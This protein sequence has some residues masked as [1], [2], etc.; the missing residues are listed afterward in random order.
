VQ[1]GRAPYA[2]LDY[3]ASAPCLQQVA[4]RVAEVLPWYSSVH[5]GTGYLSQ[6]STSLF[7][8]ARVVICDFLGARPDDVAV[9]TRNTT[10]A[11]NLLARSVPEPDRVLFLDVEHHANLLPWQRRHYRAVPA[12]PTLEETLVRLEQAMTAERVCL[13][14]ITGASNVTG[15]VTPLSA[16]VAIAH[17][18]GARVVIDAAQLAPHRPVDL[19][20]LDADYIAVSAHKCYAPFGGGILV[21]RR[22]WLDAATPYLA[23][24]GAIRT[25]ALDATVWRE[26]PE[27]HEGGTPNV[28][29]A[30][31]FGEAA[32][33]LASMDDGRR[34]RHE[35]ALQS[36]L[37]TGLDALDGFRRLRIWSDSSESVG[38]TSFTIAG[39]DTAL[40]ATYLSCEHGI[41]VREG[42][43]CAHPLFQKLNEGKGAIRASYGLGSTISE[44]DRLLEALEL[45][46]RRGAS[47]RYASADGTWS[48]LDDRRPGP[49]P[50]IASL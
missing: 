19:A 37:E 8:A 23:G 27:R 34:A 45:Y 42:R 36:R 16:I 17:R 47:W 22:D 30:I 7:E 31:A 28:V 15:E 2:N 32:G 4:D 18:H 12:A 39:H 3:A 48:P 38:I 49:F 25:V 35:A 50:E 9:F 6:V 44:I 1:G 24:G 5:R 40:V 41:G 13:L 26:S 33:A 20:G 14:A 11:L 29:G 43:F 46:L 10:D 21:G